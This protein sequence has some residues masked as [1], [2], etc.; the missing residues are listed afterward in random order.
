MNVRS[1]Y[2]LKG[3]IDVEHEHWHRVKA[4]GLTLNHPPLVNLFL[5]RGLSREDRL[6]LSYLHEFG[7]L[8]TLPLALAL[9]LCLLRHKSGRRRSASWWLVWIGRFVAYQAMWEM[10][11]EAYVTMQQGAAYRETYRRTSN[12]FLAAFWVVM[13]GL[14]AGLSGW[15]TRGKG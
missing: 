7:H 4:G 15:L 3:E 9:V 14:T 2:G 6:R 10:A 1:W 11:S 8:Q 12:L 5:R 13:G